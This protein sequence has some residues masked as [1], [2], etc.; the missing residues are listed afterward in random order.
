MVQSKLRKR[1]VTAVLS[2]IAYLLMMLEIPYPGSAFLKIDFSDVPALAAMILF[3]PGSALLVEALK[4]VLH[5]FLQGSGT[6][7]PIDQASNFIA[8]AC[9]ILPAWF[10]YKKNQTVKG[11]IMG[12]SAGILSMAVLMSVFNYYVALPVYTYFMGMPQMN[13]EQ[14]YKFIIIGILPFNLI[15]GI[16]VSAIFTMVYIRMKSWF[17][18]KSIQTG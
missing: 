7:I 14:I 12:A 10:V 11:L 15:K 6:G 13:A 4:N 5:Y 17:D 1:V 3:G 18:Q 9:L 8:G 2:S 16:L